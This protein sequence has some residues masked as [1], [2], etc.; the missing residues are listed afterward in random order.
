[1]PKGRDRYRDIAFDHTQ[2]KTR[3][4]ANARDKHESLQSK[5]SLVLI[6]VNSRYFAAKFLICEICGKPFF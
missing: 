6:R 1:L 5:S 2:T 3:V 4:A